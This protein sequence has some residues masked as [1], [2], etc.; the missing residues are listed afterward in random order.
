M[1]GST[2]GGNAL[3]CRVALEFFDLLG[4]LLP[5]INRV[6]DYFRTRLGELAKKHDFVKE[7]RGVGLMIGIELTAPCKQL[8]NEGINEGLLFNVTHD[9]VVRFLPPYILA[10]REVDIAMKKLAK[11]FRRFHPPNSTGNS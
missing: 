9:T 10:E 11:I 6:G 2:F 7:I 3:G 5:Q 8:V 4:D 1:H